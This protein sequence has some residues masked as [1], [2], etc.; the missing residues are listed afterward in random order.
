VTSFSL[1]HVAGDLLKNCA[2]VLLL[3]E[4]ERRVAEL[5]KKIFGDEPLEPIPGLA[6]LDSGNIRF[7]AEPE[8][9]SDLDS[10]PFPAWEN[11]PFQGYWFSVFTHGP[12]QKERFLP[13]LT[14]RGCPFQ[15]RFCITPEINNRWR[16]RSPVNVVDEIEHFLKIM[17]VSDFHISDL[18]PGIDEKRIR[19]ISDEIISRKLKINWKLAQGTKIDILGRDTIE[20][21]GRAGCNYIS[22]SP[23]T[24]SRELLKAMRKP[25][26]Y[27]HALE[28]VRVMD[29]NGIRSQACFIA[30]LPGEDEAAQKLTRLYIRKL[31][32]NG[33]DEIGVFGF[34][35]I[36]GSELSRYI[37][38]YAHYSECTFNPSWREDYK[39]VAAFR[40]SLYLTF[41]L[42]K[43]THPLKVLREIQRF[44]SR[45]FETKMEMSLYK[46][47]KLYILKYF[48]FLLPRLGKGK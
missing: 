6:Y 21:M 34:A 13:L 43:L 39:Q 41:F 28:M 7:T 24:G 47:I 10:L 16:A 5:T 44:F 11:Y 46:L 12:R 32:K 18:N 35:P 8:P 3:G 25:F 31:V 26:N 29:R 37:K 30:G 2:E 15:C 9:D 27:E 42:C 23:E 14:S 33:L 17:Q 48:P 40:L 4:P 36:P 22:F 1:K 38:G 45:R 20:L 19:D